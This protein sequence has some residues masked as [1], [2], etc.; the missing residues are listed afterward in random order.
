[1]TW[2]KAHYVVWKMQKGKNKKDPLPPKYTH[3]P[4]RLQIFS[5]FFGE[6]VKNQMN[7]P[8]HTESASQNIDH[9]NPPP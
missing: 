9:F 4:L 7:I 8:H 5:L 2:L 1:M 3:N 6:G